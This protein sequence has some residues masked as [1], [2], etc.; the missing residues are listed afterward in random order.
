MG[1]ILDAIDVVPAGDSVG[2]EATFGLLMPQPDGTQGWICHEAV[3]AAGALRSARYARSSD[4]AWLGWVSDIGQA[5][6]GVTLWRSVDGCDWTPAGGL[7]GE[8]VWMASFDPG[9]PTHA[10]AGTSDT[11]GGW[12]VESADGGAT[13]TRTTWGG[14][15]RGLR[16]VSISGARSVWAT[17]NHPDGDAAWLVHGS[18]GQPL[19]EVALPLPSDL[20]APV[21]ARVGVGSPS[22]PELGWIVFDAFGTDR[23]VR[24]ADGGETLQE[25]FD[26]DGEI[27]DVEVDASGGV[28]VVVGGT[29][30]FSA[31]DGVTFAPVPAFPV[32]LGVD[33][34]SA[35]RLRAT[36]RPFADGALV[37]E[38]T[39][40]GATFAP[41]LDLED[42]SGP[43]ACEA[44]STSAQICDPLWPALQARLP[45]GEDT[46]TPADTDT[47]T[48]TGSGGGCGCRSAPGAWGGLSAVVLALVGRRRAQRSTHWPPSHAGSPGG[49]HGGTMKVQV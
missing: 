40:G 28:W 9:D 37:Y 48:D 26:A 35:A 23:L 25:V 10:V 4:G 31:P 6:D 16:D 21:F 24:T 13:W 30:L 19:A 1:D 39:D 34:S 45:T 43:L 44:G 47:D 8:T 14:A 2:V 12:L 27:L 41:I 22:D 11:D 49:A 42:V 18:V 29:E 38:S 32:G 17:F 33:A 36:G 46:G 15:D 5:R 20:L 7:D 3:L